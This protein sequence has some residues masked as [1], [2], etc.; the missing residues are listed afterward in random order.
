MKMAL[1]SASFFLAF[2]LSLL[3]N[4]TYGDQAES[5]KGSQP[6]QAAIPT[7]ARIH[8]GPGP[9]FMKVE[10][11]YSRA[12]GSSSDKPAFKKTTHLNSLVRAGHRNSRQIHFG[13]GPSGLRA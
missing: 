4:F 6:T 7:A 8:F 12:H 5:P 13:P 1:K 11:S 10:H 3:T 9:R 2:Y